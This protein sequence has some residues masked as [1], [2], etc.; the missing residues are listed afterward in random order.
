MLK[1]YLEFITEKLKSSDFENNYYWFIDI[2]DSKLKNSPI[3]DNIYSRN[4]RTLRDYVSNEEARK[5]V[6]LKSVF[7]DYR[8]EFSQK[9]IKM[10][11]FY[12]EYF[13]NLAHKI[14]A[15][16][17]KDF[18]DM[19]NLIDRSGF[20][21]EILKN[22]F[23]YRISSLISESFSYFISR[24]NLD[25][26]NG[27]V[28]VYL[29]YINKELNLDADVKLSGMSLREMT[30]DEYLIKYAYGYHKT[31]YGLLFLKQN[32][33]SIEKFS[34]MAISSIKPYVQEQFDYL[35]NEI[36]DKD[37]INIEL[38]LTDNPYL[39]K[40]SVVY[41]GMYPPIPSDTARFMTI[42]CPWCTGGDKRSRTVDNNEHSVCFM[43]YFNICNVN[44]DKTTKI[45]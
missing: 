39:H 29:Y 41:S 43:P 42:F 19:Q 27:Y 28:D 17:D 18:S 15:D 32:N 30:D 23:D 20:T 3:A 24:Y 33:T 31:P 4:E 7:S 26:I 8:K 14:D 38:L 40:P 35:S 22:L 11:E 1:R 9:I 34:D 12:S 10:S 25:S 6:E 2:F 37:G 44:E 5:I 13:T 36:G 16:P 45:V 21:I